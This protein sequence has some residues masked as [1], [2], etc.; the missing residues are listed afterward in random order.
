MA[1]SRQALTRAPGAY[2]RLL[3]GTESFEAVRTNAVGELGFG[4][5][6]HI[7]LNYRRLQIDSSE[8][9]PYNRWDLHHTRS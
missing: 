7:G 9:I 2:L 1:R 4:V 3:F 5:L 6:A 8:A